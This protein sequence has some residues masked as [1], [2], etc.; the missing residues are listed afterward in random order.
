M[1]MRTD[2][3]EIDKIYKR[4]DRYE[5]PDWQREEVWDDGRKQLLIDSMLRGWR[6][7]KFYFLK[8]DSQS[9]YEVV[10]G[11]QRLS[12]IF[13]FLDNELELNSEMSGLYGGPKYKDL[14]HE[15]SDDFDDFEIDF[16][17]IEDASDQDIKE[18]FQRLQNGLP[19]NSSEKL[20]SIHSKLRDFC[21]SL[22]DHSFF[23]DHVG[24]S[25]KR[26]SHFD[27]AAKAVA[28]EI[29]GLDAGL[30]YDDLKKLFESNAGFS[31][32]SQAAKRATS[33][34]DFLAKAFPKGSKVL[35]N[36][37]I[38]QSV[39]TLASKII[40]TPGAKP[41]PLAFG[42][43]I[44][45]FLGQLSK[46]VEKG[47]SAND[48]EYLNF[49]KTVNANVKAGPR[50]RHQILLA[51]L[52][53]FDA[54]FADSV[55]PGEL[56]KSDAA[57]RISGLSDSIVEIVSK[58]NASYSS[59]NGGDLFKPTSKTASAHVVISKM[60]EDIEGYKSLIT[61]LYNEF[62]EGPGG[63]LQG[64]QPNS[65]KE[66]NALRTELQHDVDHGAAKDVAKK[67]INA[68]L[69]FEKYAGVSSPLSADPARFRI[70]QERLL[71]AIRDDL[72]VALSS[73]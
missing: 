65:F 43:F 30:R 44:E 39:I 47:H 68:G 26:Y 61:C 37:S 58:I 33:S 29:E 18:F 3:R 6:L 20:N 7:P 19:L 15:I 12:A 59:K 4:R 24:L 22:A 8:S 41:D 49:Q 50:T 56:S 28:V 21:K 27:V 9:Q 10:D 64:I 25:S 13:E 11:Q 55:A 14:K 36:R 35:R 53:L 73:T 67:K 5:I 52:V 34:L 46:E 1:K 72:V 23:K 16:D 71:A 2:K 40:S 48:A 60:V 70:V 51:K 31:D 32:Q 63:K 66:I 42:S 38:T 17:E 69:V 62:W 57:I 45:G 54:K